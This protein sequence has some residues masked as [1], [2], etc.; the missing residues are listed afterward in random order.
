MQ[1]V[2]KVCWTLNKSEVCQQ[3]SVNVTNLK[4]SQKEKCQVGAALIKCPRTNV[5]IRIV[6]EMF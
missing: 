6:T 5:I 2:S 4:F 1:I 3:V